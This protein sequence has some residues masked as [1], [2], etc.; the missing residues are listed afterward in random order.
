LASEF[1]ELKLEHQ[2]SSDT[3][4]A[5]RTHVEAKDSARTLE[6]SSFEIKRQALASEH[7]LQLRQAQQSSNSRIAQLERELGRL[8]SQLDDARDETERLTLALESGK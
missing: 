2:Q 3:H 6:A 5:F 4:D 7:A 1:R 8:R